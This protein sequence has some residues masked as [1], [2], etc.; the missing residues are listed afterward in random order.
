MNYGMVLLRQNSR[1]VSGSMSYIFVALFGLALG[2]FLNVCIGRLPRHESVVTPRSRCPYC[3]RPIRWHDNIPVLS[4]FLLRARCRDCK[5]PISARY[6]F[7]EILTAG[8]LV[9]VWAEYGPT[10]LFAK[11]ALL[12]LLLLILIFTDLADRRLPHAVTVFG[13]AAGILLSLLVPVDDRP[14]EWVLQRFDIFPAGRVSSFLGALAGGTFGGGLL[15]VVGEAFAR[16]RHKQG[17]GFGDVMLMGMIG[18]FLGIPLTY[19]TVFLGSVLEIG[20]AHV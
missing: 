9:V 15:Y 13:I 12:I 10:L 7:V 18:T 6:P 4:F 5:Q 2:S 19:V 20:R 17:L 11:C 3:G 8:L 1:D 14:L 16:L